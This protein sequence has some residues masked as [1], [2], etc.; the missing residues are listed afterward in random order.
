MSRVL[1][2]GMSGVGKSSVIGELRKKGYPAIDMDEPGWSIHN[3]EGHQLWCEDR[4]RAVLAS[5]ETDH[6][7]VSGCAENQVKFYP[8]FSHIIL[9][10]A[11]VDVIK[12]R[13]VRRTENPYG[14]RPEELTD[15]LDHLEW[16][17]PL[18]RRSATHEVATTMPLD[19]VVAT[20]LSFAHAS[21]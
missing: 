17:E 6:L 16:V 14:K 4:L 9:M 13:L 10:S 5:P 19:R 21:R 1:L 11:P 12:E 2:T 7:F 8:Q 20:V 18:L 3:A 15:V